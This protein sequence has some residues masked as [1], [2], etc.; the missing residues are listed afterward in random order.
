MFEDNPAIRMMQGVPV[1]LD[2]P[3]GFAVWDGGWVIQLILAVWAILTTTRLL[4]GEE[5]LER[6]DLLLAG[7]VRASTA[8]I[9][10]L[11]VRRLPPRGAA[12]IGRRGHDGASA[13]PGVT[14]SLLLGAALAGVTATFV[15]AAAICLA[16]R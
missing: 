7:P 13:G 8:T 12:R 16:A 3:G 11:S 1:A 4:R 5:D 9:T 10:V 2:T 6:T 14:G 15:A